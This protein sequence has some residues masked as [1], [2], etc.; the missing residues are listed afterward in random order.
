MALTQVSI[1]AGNQAI[2]VNASPNGSV[3]TNGGPDTVYY[4]PTNV[5]TSA[6]G[7]SIAAAA[8]ATLVGTQYLVVAPTAGARADV[9]ILDTYTGTE[10]GHVIADSLEVTG[11]AALAS[12]LAVTGA[13]TLTGAATLASTA[14]IAGAVTATKATGTG[15]AV[16]ANETVGGTLAVTGTS[17]LADTV[18]ATKATGTGLAVTANGTVGG[19][20]AVTGTASTGAL[21]STGV[22]VGGAL[23]TATTGAFSGAVTVGGA[24]GVT[25]LTTATGGLSIADATDVTIGTSTGTKI[26]QASS[27]VGFFGVAPAAQP[28]A[29]TKTYNTALKTIANATAANVVTTGAGLASYGYTQAQADAIP[30]AIN[31]TQADVLALKKVVVALVTDLQALGL[32]Q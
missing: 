4:G 5:V 27:K 9:Q 7:T 29:Y 18:S 3:F 19:T 32:A 8:T 22:A 28:S 16:T 14:A 12:T 21:T 20:L 15:L 24:L 17:T 30:V 1:K 25:G 6:D 23:T 31:A 13:S 10:E 2:P 26:G 11:P